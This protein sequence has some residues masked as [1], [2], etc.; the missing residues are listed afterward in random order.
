MGVVVRGK[1]LRHSDFHRKWKSVMQGL[2][3]FIALTRPH[4]L[5]MHRKVHSPSKSFLMFTGT[6]GTCVL[7]FFCVQK[8]NLNTDVWAQTI[9]QTAHNKIFRFKIMVQW[10]SNSVVLTHLNNPIVLCSC[11]HCVLLSYTFELQKSSF[12]TRNE[13]S[14]HSPYSNCFV[15]Y[16]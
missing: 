15:L 11:A 16:S 4:V 8:A 1:E 6:T 2:L 13:Q 3:S 5:Q 10:S 14:S 7:T 9:A 12:L